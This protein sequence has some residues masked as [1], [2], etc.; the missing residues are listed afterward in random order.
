MKNLLVFISLFLGFQLYAS[1]IVGGEMY[2]DC[3]GNNEYKVTI[4]VYRDCNSSGAD[5]DI[6][7][8]LGVFDKVTN[9][10]IDTYPVGFPGSQNLPVTF[11]NPCVTPPTNICVQEAVYTKTI[12]LPAS[13]NGYTLV[14]ER[15]CRGPGIMNLMNPADEGLTL[16]AEIP[17]NA[18][19]II[20]NSSPRY[21]NYPPLLLCNNDDLVFDHSATDPDGDVL[22]YELCTPNHGG[23]SVNPM[24]NP[25]NYP[26]YNQIL[27]EIGF[28]ET[29][30]FGPNGPIN[31]DPNTGLLTAAP[32]LIGKFVVG[33][34]VSEY[35]NGV[36][37]STTSRDF[38]F[39]VFN[40]DVSAAAEIVPQDELL[41]F[42][43]ECDGL[44]IQFENNSFGG[45]HYLWDFGVPSDPN[46]TSTQFAPTYTFPSEGIFEVTL[47]LN[48]GW[49]CSDSS[50]QTFTVYEGMDISFPPSDPQCIVDNAFDFEGEGS[51]DAEATFVWN[52]GPNASPSLD[53]TEDV[54][55]VSYDSPGNYPISF[56]VTFNSC[57]D[58]YLDTIEVHKP[59]M[60]DFD[61]DSSL[62]CAP[63]Q[64]Q[65]YDSSEASSELFY[66]WSFGDGETSNEVNPIHNYSQP[67]IYDVSLVIRTDEGCIDT[68][69]MTKE[70]LVQ[71]YTP[72]VA[73]FSVSPEV[74]NVF[75]T[76]IFF[77]DLSIDSEQHFYQLDSLT[78]TT[79]RNLSFHYIEGGYHYPYQVVTNEFGCKDTAV[80]TIF[81]EP[82]TTFYV[83]TA[84]TPDNDDYNELFL[85][86]ILDVSNYTFEIYNR[87]GN[88]IFETDNTKEG[89]NGRINGN[90]APDGVYV[91]RIKYR[92]HRDIYHEHQGYFS[93][94]R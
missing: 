86:I 10:R 1:H 48:P 35:R 42:N 89:W 20:C 59:P 78:S 34:C 82:Q 53:T 76:E 57:V 83:P 2:Y 21:S 90:V 52:F 30:P 12:T 81:V 47:Y 46:S 68:L 77:S 72:P 26:P 3:L 61:F 18:N 58:T 13:A 43:S 28:S 14:Y 8:F 49:P 27:W 56:T 17:G 62:F 19:G 6:P 55:G 39:T 79:D 92:N 5:F 31:I 32:D 73:D 69:D 85:P 60:I 11:S 15:C 87:W 88:K 93:L 71:V 45:T 23:S 29:I 75:E 36:L 22:V 91:W 40:C 38:L 50:V 63:D 37:I 66:T 25:P 65:F 9:N 67:G 84:F 80:R 94:L 54:F 64:V 24:P 33:V 4:K 7:L 44:T 70:D 51:Y 41:T 16:T 74:T